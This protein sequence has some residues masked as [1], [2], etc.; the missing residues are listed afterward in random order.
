M[1]NSHELV[2][3]RI[4]VNSSDNSLKDLY[5]VGNSSKGVHVCAIG[6][7]ANPSKLVNVTSI[8]SHVIQLLPVVNCRNAERPSSFKFFMNLFKC[9][10]L[11]LSASVTGLPDNSFT[12]FLLVTFFSLK[13]FSKSSMDWN[14]L[15]TCKPLTIGAQQFAMYLGFWI[16]S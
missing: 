6:L 12:N 2:S 10:K 16:I 13:I 14:G 11:S 9:S 15:N 4:L 5:V 7:R 3:L 1:L 8:C